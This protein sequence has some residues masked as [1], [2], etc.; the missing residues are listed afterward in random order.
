MNTRP[1]FIFLVL[2][3]LFISCSSSKYVNYLKEHTEVVKTSDSL[4]FQ[5]LN[6]SFYQNKL[7]LVG[8][9][10]EVATSPRIDFAMFTQLH[11]K[12]NI[13]IYLAEMDIAQA[14]YLNEYI[15]GSDEI[16][17]KSILKKWPVFIG[18]ISK[19][20]RNKWIKMRHY[21]S[22]LP[23]K[24]KFKLVGIDR[25]SDFDLIRKLLQEKLPEKYHHYIDTQNDSLIF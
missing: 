23:K 16:E 7:F 3:L 12:I 22:Q 20:Y 25:I 9:V 2:V 19:Q 24:L 17:L 1:L 21:Y 5:S 13:D 11:H 10:H 4:Q 8:E 18:R 15:K 6:D 14:Y